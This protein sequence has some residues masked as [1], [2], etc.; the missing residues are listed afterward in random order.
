[1]CSDCHSNYEI[2]TTAAQG[3]HGSAVKWMLKGRNRAW[4]A[5]S[6]GSNGAG[7]DGAKLYAVHYGGYPAGSQARRYENDG[8]ADGLFCLNCH[9]T[10]GF[11]KGAD[12][13]QAVDS[14]GQGGPGVNQHLSHHAAFMSWC[15]MA[16]S[17]PG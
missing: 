11:S 5:A 17:S 6:A 12:G 3:P 10:V 2:S 8:T 14:R 4:P 15:H 7:Y 1:M 9:S 16:A 13:L